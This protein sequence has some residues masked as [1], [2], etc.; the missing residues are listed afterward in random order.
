MEKWRIWPVSSHS[1]W[2][3][4]V[5]RRR[6]IKMNRLKLSSAAVPGTRA[7][8][9]V[10]KCI[11]PNLGA[12][13]TLKF[14]VCLVNEGPTQR[15]WKFSS[16]YKPRL[17][18]GVLKAPIKSRVLWMYSKWISND[19]Y[20]AFPRKWY[21]RATSSLSIIPP[22]T[23]KIYGYVLYVYNDQINFIDVYPICEGK[24]SSSREKNW[25]SVKFNYHTGIL[26]PFLSIQQCGAPHNPCPLIVNR[27][28]DF[29]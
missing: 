3:N 9:D 18:H 7:S 27:Q 15:D 11:T 2:Y 12:S 19:V 16:T 29:M 5:S 17:L 1:R 8:N 20:S 28:P 21:P 6:S 4:C 26:F 10:P 22:C 25:F 14:L 13:R 23:P 24:C